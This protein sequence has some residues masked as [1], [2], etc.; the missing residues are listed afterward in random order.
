MVEIGITNKD[1]LKTI[2][3][4]KYRKYDLLKNELGM[5]HKCEVE[6]IPYVMTWD[7]LTTKCYKTYRKRLEIDKHVEAI[8]SLLLSKKL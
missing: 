3:T 6:V 4:E 1:R 2:E 5:M 7:G 8:Y